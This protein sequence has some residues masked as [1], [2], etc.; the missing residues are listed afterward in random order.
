MN[1]KINLYDTW[2]VNRTIAH[3]GLHD[4]RLPENSLGAF[5]AAVEKGYA[6]ETDLQLT[7]DGVIVV[8]HDEKMKRMTG[9][10]L[11]INDCMYDE[12]KD[13][14]LIGGENE[15]IPTLEQ[16]L[17]TVDGKVPLLIEIK[18]HENIGS[19]EAPLTERLRRYNGKFAVQSFNPFIVKWFRKN[20]P[21][22]VRGQLAAF[23]DAEFGNGVRA[24]LQRRVLRNCMLNGICGAQFTSYDTK[25]IKRKRLLRIKK[26]MPVLMWTVRTPERLESC[27]GYFD[28]IIFEDFLPPVELSKQKL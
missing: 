16:L 3:R 2:L 25:G 9:R 7:A 27:K 8:F 12:I 21:E 23:F 1:K 10:E 13:I 28:N 22:F 14:P 24:W 4:E 26:K 15:Y 17:E 18:T 6:I 5:R 19:L 20:A 11:V